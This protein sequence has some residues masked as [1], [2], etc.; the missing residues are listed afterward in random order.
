MSIYFKALN[1]VFVVLLNAISEMQKSKFRKSILVM[2]PLPRWRPQYGAHERAFALLQW[3]KPEAAPPPKS[4]NPRRPFL[5][6]HWASKELIGSNNPHYC[7]HF[8]ENSLFER[9]SLGSH[10]EMRDWIASFFT[11]GEIFWQ[12][13][14]INK[15]REL[16]R[17]TIY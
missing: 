10:T 2:C 17:I 1:L 11:F 15:W 7:L 12:I 5:T 14:A 8:A 4:Q 16:L 3:L 13:Y 9:L 6:Y